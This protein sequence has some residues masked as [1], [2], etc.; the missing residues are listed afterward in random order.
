MPYE[1]GAH[2]ATHPVATAVVGRLMGLEPTPPESCRV[3]ELGCATGG[4]LGPMAAQL[5]GSEFVGLDISDAQISTARQVARAA[6]LPNVR[7][8]AMDIMD[9][10]PGLGAFDYIIC[11][12]VYSWVPAAVRSRILSLCSEL[13]AP[14]GL[15]Y[16]SYNTLPGAQRRKLAS[17][18]A[19]F[20]AAHILEEEA[21]IPQVLALWEAVADAMPGPDHPVAAQLKTVLGEVEGQEGFYIA[22]EYL[23]D[24]NEPAWFWEVARSAQTQGLQYVGESGRPRELDDFPDGVREKIRI[25]SPDL[26]AGEQMLDLASN[27]AFRRSL[28]CH[29]RIHLDRTPSADR[30]LPLVAYASCQRASE[31]GEGV[32]FRTRTGRSFATN[33]PLLISALDALED[34]WPGGIQLEVLFDTVISDNPST[35]AA[36]ERQIRLF[37]A[38]LKLWLKNAITL[39]ASVL[40]AATR[41]PDRPLAHPL[42]RLQAREGRPVTNLLHQTVTLPREALLLLPLLDGTRGRDELAANWTASVDSP[43]E[44]D[45]SPSGTVQEYLER[46]MRLGLLSPENGS[47]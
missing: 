47:V 37:G 19:R 33:D 22:H 23:E 28:F 40:P 24:V 2:F 34:A 39:A 27:T 30:L 41:V 14:N 1:G 36:E 12:G 46:F 3:L 7:Y 16:V 42:T 6:E 13:L 31:E 4:N 43:A 38:L 26:V 21:P 25:L 5:P 35:S 8:E 17:G 29:D 11:H 9:A 32:S 18:V 45:G 10:G 20:G 44:R 15:A